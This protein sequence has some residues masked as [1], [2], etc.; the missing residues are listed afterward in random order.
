MT[1]NPPSDVRILVYLTWAILFRFCG[2]VVK[3]N[4]EIGTKENKILI[5]WTTTY[6]SATWVCCR[7]IHTHLRDWNVGDWV[8]DERNTRVQGL[9]Y[10]S[11]FGC[12]FRGKRIEILN[13]SRQI[14]SEQAIKAKHHVG[15]LPS[16][17]TQGQIVGARD[18]CQKTF[19]FFC[20]IRRQNGGDRL[21]LVW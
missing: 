20:P 12:Q 19:V 17:E 8:A 6:I 11:V 14:Y 5:N 16:S 9:V 13:N 10:S 18:W 2:G 1:R 21:E 3:Y 4:N 7:S 15:V